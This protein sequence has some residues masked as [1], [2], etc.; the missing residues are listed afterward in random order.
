MT[1]LYITIDTE[2]SAG[3]AMREGLGD[4]VRRS[5]FRSSI[6]GAVGSDGDAEEVGIGYQMDIFDLYGLKAVFFVDPLPALIWGVEAVADIVQPIVR[7]G[8]DVQLHM[9]TEWLELA[10]KDNPFDGLTGKHMRDF[11]LLAQQAILGFGRDV[12]IEAGA[13]APVA[14]RAGNYGANDDTLRALSRLGIGYDTSHCPGVPQSA[15]RLSL[16]VDDRAPLEHCG[17]IEVPVSCIAAPGDTLRHFQLTAVSDAEILAA[18]AHARDEGQESMTLVSHSFELLSR[19]RTRVN[20]I[21]RRRFERMCRGVARMSGV[22]SAT[23]RHNPPRVAHD[24]HIAPLP[25]SASRTAWRYAE[26]AL[27]NALYGGA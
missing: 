10:G 5:N 20:P 7:R 19:D 2:Y 23:Y 18:L 25:Y 13:P 16:G 9:H 4:A 21:L 3:R 11:P 26:Q 6:L 1:D 14:F 24:T 15:S 27:G 12:L 17:V 8:H 22:R